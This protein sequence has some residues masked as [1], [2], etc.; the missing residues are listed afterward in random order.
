MRRNKMCDLFG[1]SCNE[2]DRATRSLPIFA[3]YS[4][5]DQDGWGIVYYEGDRAVLRRKPTIASESR[6]FLN[7]IEQA[8]S[9]IIISHLR[10]ATKGEVC[11]RNCHPF[12]QH[13]NGRDWAFAHNGGVHGIEDHPRS[14]GE[15]DS[16]DVFNFILDKMGGYISEGQI[17][18]LYPGIIKAVSSLFDNYGRDIH[19]NFLMTDGDILY[20]FHHYDSKPIYFLRRAKEYGGA[21]LASTR[22]LTQEPW[23]TIPKN[24][25]MLISRGDVLILSDPI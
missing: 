18:G 5:I 15:T 1:M 22:K 23:K 2:K 25:L 17:H 3:Q 14:E 6:E 16:E 24:R 13:A 4:R 20:A 8:K 7:T 10:L 12:V 11:E 9:N 21:L 19:L